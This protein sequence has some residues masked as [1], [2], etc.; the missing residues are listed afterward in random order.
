MCDSAYRHKELQNFTIQYNT[1]QDTTIHYFTIRFFFVC[2]YPLIAVIKILN[3]AK[4][5]NSPLHGMVFY[6]IG[7]IVSTSNLPNMP[8]FCGLNEPMPT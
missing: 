2:T 1:V 7:L 4:L 6:F 3:N 8:L 5:H